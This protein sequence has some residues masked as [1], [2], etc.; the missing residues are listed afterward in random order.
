MRNRG[1]LILSLVLL[2][3]LLASAACNHSSGSSHQTVG[4]AKLNVR[5]TDAPIDLANVQ[6]VNV[7]LTDVIV[8]PEDVTGTMG[9]PQ[10]GDMMET[11]S[12]TQPITLMSHP[13]TFD[14]LTLT[15]GTSV[16]L[17]SGEVPAGQYSRIRLDIS[18]AAIVYKDGTTAPL[19][20]DS[21]KVDIP[22]AFKLTVNADS[23]ITLDFNAAA[24]VQVNQTASGALILRPVVTAS[25]TE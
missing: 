21:N 10:P 5:L 14:L 13:A 19:K 18:S 3:C 2:P 23:S 1:A 16:L 7:T 6:S 24:S 8:Y 15:G 25:E 11:E 12:G 9:T 20:I 4:T 17:A 22:L